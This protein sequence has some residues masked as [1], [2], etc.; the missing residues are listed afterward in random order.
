MKTFL[1]AT[2]ALTALAVALPAIAADLYI[3]TTPVVSAP[4]PVVSPAP[5]DTPYIDN[6]YDW[7]GFYAGIT[8]GYAWGRAEH[9]GGGEFDANGYLLGGTVGY[10]M[11]MDDFVYGIEGDLVWTDIAGSTAAVAT[12]LDWVGTLRARAGYDFDGIMPYVTGGFAL[13]RINGSSATYAVSETQLGL[14]AGAGLEVGVTENISL[15]AEYAYTDFGGDWDFNSGNGV[16]LDPGSHAIKSGIR[17][18]F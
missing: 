3:P 14:T 7:S 12:D 8:G 9:N 6:G 1:R 5:V 11:Q 2:V 15:N 10:N 18:G 16:D 13:A 4:A 17:F